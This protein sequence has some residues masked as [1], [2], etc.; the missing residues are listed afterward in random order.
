MAQ[1]P[2][3]ARFRTSLNGA[4]AESV[5]D[6]AKEWLRCA[7]L[8]DVVS[9]SL[10]A[11]ADKDQR[12]GGRTG[13]AMGA[14]FRR[15][16]RSVNE[17]A[18]LLREGKA[19]LE[20]AAQVIEKAVKAQ[21]AMD[22]DHPAGTNPGTWNRPVGPLTE[23]DLDAQRKHQAKVNEY[24][25]NAAARERISQQWTENIDNVF[26]DSTEVMKKI[27]GEPDPEPPKGTDE[28]K[29]GSINPTRGIPQGPGESDPRDP[30]G[31]DPRDPDDT[32]PGDPDDPDA[33]DPRDPD[34]TNPGDPDDTN[35]GD[36]DD[37]GHIPPIGSDPGGNSGGVGTGTLGGLAVGAGGG[38]LALSGLRNG[39]LVLPGGAVNSNGVRPI[40]STG[41]I[42]TSGALGR[43][44]GAIAPGSPVTRS[45]AAAG[46]GG[47]GRGGAA[48]T[49]SPVG[50]GGRGGAG[51]RG[52]GRG[53]RAGVG[54]IG[55]G[56]G[57][58]KKDEEKKQ[59]PRDLFDDGDDWIDDEGAAPD[60]LS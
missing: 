15:T 56:R 21:Q 4:S 32:N 18:G 5:Q 24:Q 6:G 36:S 39:G 41:R 9:R 33:N 42:G 52:A 34:D 45:G 46:R 60:V 20:S 54:G 28:G 35:A 8:L 43:G 50:R 17:R 7:E 2:N 23:E 13:P 38:A 25:E 44:A 49:G 55:T 1:G 19:A 40:G 37:G 12:I 31:S 14:A 3:E 10:E 29:P 22:N 59:A 53:G 27:H 58:G 26:A 11:A 47:V 30:D 48:G 57:K 16:S 51:G